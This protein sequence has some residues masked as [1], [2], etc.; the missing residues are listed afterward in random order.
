MV[1]SNSLLPEKQHSLW[2]RIIKQKNKKTTT[3]YF[4]LI[5][6]HNPTAKYPTTN[7]HK[8]LSCL[9]Y[10]R[11]YSNTIIM[12]TFQV[13]SR[14][15]FFPVFHRSAV[16]NNIS[17]RS[18]MTFE[19]KARLRVRKR[20]KSILFLML[21]NQPIEYDTNYCITELYINSCEDSNLPGI[22]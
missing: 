2:L 17:R 16:V 4:V 1:V 14:R 3:R 20:I 13:A 5:R 22:I 10:D 19:D 18:M 21:M 12:S 8:L 11:Q 7:N 9:R 15:V 6:Y